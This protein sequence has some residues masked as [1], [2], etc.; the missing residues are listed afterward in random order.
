VKRVEE[1]KSQ[2]D[3]QALIEVLGHAKDEQVRQAALEALIEIALSLAAEKE[4]REIE[5]FFQ[6]LLQAGTPGEASPQTPPE[7][8]NAARY[9]A[10]I[11]ALGSMGAMV[12][13]QLLSALKNPQKRRYAAQI[14]EQIGWQPGLDENGALYWIAKGEW[15]RCAALGGIAIAPLLLVLQEQDNE[16]RRAAAHVLGQIGDARAVEPLL[17][18]LVDQDA[19]VRQAAIEAIGQIG[20]PHTVEALELALQDREGSVRLAAT[21]ALGQIGSPRAVEALIATLQGRFAHRLLL[22]ELD[23]MKSEDAHQIAA[24]LSSW[25]ENSAPV[26]LLLQQALKAASHPFVVYLLTTILTEW[27]NERASAIEALGR[28]GDS[29]AVEPLIAALKDEDVNVRWPAARALGE[30]KDTRAIKPLIAALKDWHSNVRKAAAK[31][32]VKIGTPAVELLIA[33]LRDEDE[34]VRQAAAEA[35]DHLGWKPARDENAAWYWATKGKWNACVDIGA[36]AVQPLITSLRTNDPYM[37]RDVAQALVR[38]YQKA[39]IS[40]E[41][42]EQILAVRDRLIRIHDDQP[43]I[44]RSRD[45]SRPHTDTELGVEFPL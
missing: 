38:L 5:D 23:K 37:R 31:A 18:L 43:H 28:I 25:D 40:Q 32:L 2:R 8:E 41:D 27:K 45:C 35:L 26:H 13:P 17:A 1:M 4:A 30:I 14:L 22:E 7:D 19:K 29:R 15:D 39:G 44:D 6:R 3:V 34:R 24:L 33:A 36:P 20:D 11:Q 42:R 10:A 16:T 9:Q 12:I 21:R